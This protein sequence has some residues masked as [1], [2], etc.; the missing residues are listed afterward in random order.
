MRKASFAL[1]PEGAV[2]IGFSAFSAL[3][4]S[5]LNWWIPALCFWIFCMF[6][7]H[8][9]RDPE[10]VPPSE[11]NVAASPADG[12][13]IRIERRPDPFTGSPAQCV[14]IFM[15]V[16]NVHVNRAPVACHVE[17]IKYIAGKFFNASLDKA[18]SDNERCLWLLRAEDGATWSMVQ[19]AGLIAR[20]IVCRAQVGDALAIGERLGM[21][22]FGSRVDLYLPE[23]Y[24]PAVEIGAK[25]I[26]GQTVVARKSR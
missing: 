8:F 13:V 5:I 7:T 11:A 12:T 1:C 6:A 24:D 21:I 23:D 3:F 18:S 15:S 25:V 26:A 20:R 9:F 22:R 19:I 16:F 17:E 10:T 2:A 4:F 14:S